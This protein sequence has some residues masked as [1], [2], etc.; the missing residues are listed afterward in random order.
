MPSR[1]W[2]RPII[3]LTAGGRRNPMLS[4]VRRTGTVRRLCRSAGVALR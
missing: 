2:A 1:H 3:S 4:T